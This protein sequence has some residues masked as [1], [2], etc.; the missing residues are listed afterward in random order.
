MKRELKLFILFQTILFI[1]F[2]SLAR[3]S[4][5]KKAPYAGMGKI[6]RVNGRIRTKS[7]SG[8][9]KRTSKGYTYVNPYSRTREN[10]YG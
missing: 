3:R 1:P 5:T 6:S 9:S 4:Y 10:A 7:V 2:E 8:H